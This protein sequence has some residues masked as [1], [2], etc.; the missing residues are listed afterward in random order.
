[1]LNKICS[2]SFPSP[3]AP[4][5]Y[6]PHILAAYLN[7]GLLLSKQQGQH[8]QAVHWLSACSQLDGSGV[9]DP[10]A[11]RHSQI[12]ALVSW[13]Q[14]ELARG[15]PETSIQLYKQAIRRTPTNLQ[16]V[17]V[18]TPPSSI[19]SFFFFFFLNKLFECDRTS[20][21]HRS[22][23]TD[24]RR[25]HHQNPCAR[26]RKRFVGSFPLAD[27]SSCNG[28]LYSSLLSLGPPF[29][30]R[31]AKLVHNAYAKDLHK[32]ATFPLLRAI[33]SSSL[34]QNKMQ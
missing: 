24:G 18:N 25:H 23:K 12:Q 14:L 33:P 7:L 20:S 1:M 22:I 30:P 34:P 28:T 2:F 26:M 31:L 10:Q 11:H 19:T 13:G 27:Q 21:F 15:H 6:L 29:A 16:Q 4:S 17:Q 3:A 5:I 9:R 8:E 32:I